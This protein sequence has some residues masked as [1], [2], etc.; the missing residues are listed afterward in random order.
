[1]SPFDPAPD[2]LEAT[3]RDGSYLIDFQFTADDT[4]TVASALEA[5]GFRWI[6]VG[7]GVGMNASATGKTIQV[8]AY[9][10]MGLKKLTQDFFEYEKF[11]IEIRLADEG[12][13]DP[14]T[15]I[16]V[17]EFDQPGLVMQ[18]QS[19]KV[20]SC[21]MQH[22]PITQS[23]AYRFDANDRSIVISGDTAY[24]PEL[25]RFAKGQGSHLR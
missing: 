14:R 7:H 11:D 23:Y 2:I 18:I 21:R 12:G 22:P 10:P 24:C 5:V 17:H 1:M 3:L 20:T 16:A 4:A 19:V 9:G 6:E 13:V 15:Q 25:A 8:D